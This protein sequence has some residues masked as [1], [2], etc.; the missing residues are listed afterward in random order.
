MKPLPQTP[1]H[2]RFRAPALSFPVLVALVALSSAAC[3]GGGDATGSGGGGH[4]GGST[5]GGSTATG[6]A[7]SNM[8][9]GFD[10][11]IGSCP[12]SSTLIETSDWVTCL[13][14]KRLS[15]TDPFSKKSCELRVGSEGALDYYRDGAAAIAVPA[16][17]AWRGASGTYQK[18][19]R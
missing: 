4:S 3:S 17:G 5:A 7:S 19:Q 12:P 15:G 9:S 6:G 16:R 18:E 11:L 13:E 1:L 2:A 14:G 8:G 10:E